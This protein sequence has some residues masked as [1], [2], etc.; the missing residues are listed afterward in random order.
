MR[1]KELQPLVQ[2]LWPKK[3]TPQTRKGSPNLE[4]WHL[5]GARCVACSEGVR[6]LESTARQAFSLARRHP[7]IIRNSG[8]RRPTLYLILWTTKSLVQGL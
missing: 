8:I 4:A 3:P 1:C 5:M 2:K 7:S 6:Q